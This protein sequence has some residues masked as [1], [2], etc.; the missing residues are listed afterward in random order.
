MASLEW[1]ESLVAPYA[2]ITWIRLNGSP[3][4][5]AELSAFVVPVDRRLAPLNDAKLGRGSCAVKAIETLSSELQVI[6]RNCPSKSA[7]GPA[8]SK[9]GRNPGRHQAVQDPDRLVSRNWSWNVSHENLSK[10]GLD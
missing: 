2:S 1:E 6:K 3:A 7:A 9:S 5:R 4:F 10:N 8:H